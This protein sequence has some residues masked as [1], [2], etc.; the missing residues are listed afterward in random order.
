MSWNGSSTA[1]LVCGTILR[2]R[3]GTTCAIDSRF[4]GR[5]FPGRSVFWLDSERVIRRDGT[6]FDL[7]CKE[8]A[9]FP[10]AGGWDIVD[11]ADAK[12]WVALGG[13]F[14]YLNREPGTQPRF[15]DLV[16]ARSTQM[17]IVDLTSRLSVKGWDAGRK[18]A[19]N[20]NIM[21]VLG[22]DAICFGDPAFYESDK[23]YLRCARVNGGRE[24]HI[25]WG[26]RSS[27]IAGSAFSSSRIVLEKW[28]TARP[29]F[30]LWWAPLL[31]PPEFAHERIVL[32]LNSG[33]T[34]ASWKVRIQQDDSFVRST[35]FSAISP[36]GSYIAESGEARLDLDQLGP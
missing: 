26:L 16:T 28:D 2:V 29:P 9:H 14:R 15:A 34:I 3:D 10:I 17:M 7:G 24:I 21:Q 33:H 20:S 13:P 27:R 32:D 1:I 31:E 22:G 23:Q 36:D 12:R 8:A 25:P 5:G 11:V 30:W 18:T 35:Y 19:N 6:I 4:S